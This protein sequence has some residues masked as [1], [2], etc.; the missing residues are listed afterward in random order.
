M[1]TLVTVATVF[2]VV[3]VTVGLLAWRLQAE[4][5]TVAGYFIRAAGVEMSRFWF[6]VT[7]EVT[8]DVV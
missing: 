5:M 6:L 1:A 8:V 4:L 2:V 3:D 7:V